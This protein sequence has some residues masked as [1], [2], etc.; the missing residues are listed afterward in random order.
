MRRA[1]SMLTGSHPRRKM[2]FCYLYE[3]FEVLVEMVRK[4]NLILYQSELVGS[5]NRR[6]ND[7]ALKGNVRVGS[8]RLTGYYPS[9]RTEKKSWVSPEGEF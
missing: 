2:Y 8:S 4:G 1:K 5:S 3:R 7:L 9:E 6:K